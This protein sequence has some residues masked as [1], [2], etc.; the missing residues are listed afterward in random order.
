MLKIAVIGGT[1]R[2]GSQVVTLLNEGGHE[3]IALSRSTGLDLLS[4]ASVAD[5]LKGFDVVVNLTNTTDVDTA[6]AFF[7]QSTANMVAAAHTAG[8]GHAVVLS[9]VGVDLAPDV[10]YYRAKVLQE[11]ALRAG[12]VPYTIVRATQFFEFVDDILSWTSDEHTV[13]LPATLL[14]P[15]AGADVAR[16]VADVSVAAPLNG[17]LDV[18][19]PD[20][21]PLD[22]LGR[23]TLAARDD[24]RPVVTDDSAGLFAA[25]PRDALIAK[26]GARIAPTT[27]REWLAR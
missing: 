2:I 7:E 17:I 22:E 24:P 6:A 14:Q 19:G 10:A 21:F 3:A 20:V 1:G 11:N 5:A 16:A 13:R 8:V 25:A 26:D 18:A 27:Y 9:I 12:S 15:I 23:I 4:E